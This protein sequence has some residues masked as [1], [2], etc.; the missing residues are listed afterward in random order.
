M[1]SPV[2]HCGAIAVVRQDLAGHDSDGVDLQQPEQEFHKLPV[3]AGHLVTIDSDGPVVG[4]VSVGGVPNRPARGVHLL[5]TITAYISVEPW[6]KC[7]CR[8]RVQRPLR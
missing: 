1:G 6:M 8:R 3:E 4:H 5:L 2:C 7:D